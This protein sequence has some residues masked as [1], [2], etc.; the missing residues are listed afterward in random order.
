MAKKNGNNPHQPK[1][2]GRPRRCTN[3]P[4]SGACQKMRKKNHSLCRD[5]K[6]V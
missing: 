3:I 2:K 1:I 4:D 6:A 5:C